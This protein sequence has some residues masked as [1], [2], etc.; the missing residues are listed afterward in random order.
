MED[1]SQFQAHCF[2]NI[3]VKVCGFL[4]N[5]ASP[6]SSEW[7]PSR[8]NNLYCFWS[9]LNIP[10]QQLM[11]EMFWGQLFYFFQSMALR[12]PLYPMWYNIITK[13]NTHICVITYA[14]FKLIKSCFS[15]DFSNILSVI[16][17]YL[18]P[19]RRFSLHNTSILIS[20][21]VLIFLITKL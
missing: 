17:S 7:Q 14:F 19:L 3:I 8:G 11:F 6:S 10:D 9:L 18:L 4:S 13:K 16:Y 5:R 1:P 15:V 21:L 12:S 20:P 2:N